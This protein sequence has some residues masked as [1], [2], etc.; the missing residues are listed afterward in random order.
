MSPKRI[1]F[2]ASWLPEPN[3]PTKGV[4]VLK[5]ARA[6]ASK[7]PVQLLYAFGQENANEYEIQDQREGDLQI[8]F[9]RYPMAKNGLVAN[10]AFLKAINYGYQSLRGEGLKFD[11]IH[12]NVLF[13]V[14]FFAWYLS[15]KTKIPYVITEHLDL[16]LRDLLGV[17]KA[18]LAGKLMRSF[19][20]RRALFNTV[21]SAP[22][23]SA[24][25]RFGL[26]KNT[27]VWPNVVEF[28]AMP[29][30]EF[31]IYKKD[32]P[33]LLHISSLRD[34][35]KNIN[36][37][38]DALLLLK[39]KR[40]DFSFHFIGGG[41]ERDRHEQRAAKLGILNSLVFFEGYVSEDEKQAW[42]EKG[43]GHIMHSHFE[44]FSVVTAEAI[45]AGLPVIVSNVGGPT[46]FVNEGNGY[47]IEKGPAA[48]AH[49]LNDLLDNYKKFD[50]V[51]I[52]QEIRFR[53]NA[54]QVAKDFEKLLE[55]YSS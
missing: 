11:L 15:R 30:A 36:G 22:M 51:K 4:F 1:L 55:S 48:L 17:E 10:W 45:G 9:V 5:H 40:T 21:C 46:D 49:A 27:K 18:L 6:L 39:N 53:F 16:F 43:I 26:A 33:A 54:D 47:L 37:L 31:P 23:L 35:Q 50:R 52:A 44:G 8:R 38:L 12:A 7:M 13:P 2:L 41:S 28:G 19:I 29:K 24:F 20:H 3:A 42:L 32:K 25:E 14:G 34:D